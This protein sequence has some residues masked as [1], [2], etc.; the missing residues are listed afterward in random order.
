RRTL[1]VMVAIVSV[2]ILKAHTY[3]IF[4]PPNYNVLPK[5]LYFDRL[6]STIQTF[7]ASS[8]SSS[9]LASMLASS[10]KNTRHKPN[11][12]ELYRHAPSYSSSSQPPSKVP[13]MMWSSDKV[14]P[15]P[16]WERL[17]KE[18]GFEPHFLNDQMAEDWVENNFRGTDVKRAWDRLPRTILKA[19]LLRYLLLLVE[20]GT[21]SDMDTVPMMDVDLWSKD[22]V[23]LSVDRPLSS[24][25]PLLFS[26]PSTKGS[27]PPTIGRQSI[28]AVIGI[29][30]DPEEWA[31]L[32]SLFE[33]PRLLPLRRHRELQFVQWT[34]HIS[35]HHPI[36]IDV[37]RRVLETDKLFQSFEI[38]RER[39]DFSDEY[40]LAGRAST[41]PSDEGDKLP[42]TL[43]PWKKI[44]M[45]WKYQDGAWRWGWDPLCVEEWTGPAVWT[46]SIVSY[47]DA[48]AGVKPADLALLKRPVQV[49]D[50]VIVPTQGFNPVLG[51]D[52]AT[53]LVHLFRGSWKK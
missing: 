20:G 13:R 9:H 38:M 50:L 39:F 25:Q 52:D 36:L 30:T 47:L 15:S 42:T 49:R 27:E 48:V 31:S 5:E 29:E 41:S 43:E 28:R 12:A 17:W 6:N 14:P 3:V 46:D 44:G 16:G 51:R 8:Q 19:D 26:S 37:I 32:R 1:L 35:P 7:F 2:V 33:K 45:V 24:V 53:R 40:G 18:K 23:P 22:A 10:L 11:S 4:Q 34:M 21:W